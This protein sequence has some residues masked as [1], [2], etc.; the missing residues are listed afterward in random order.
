MDPSEKTFERLLGCLA[1]DRM[2]RS[3]SPECPGEVL[4]ATYMD[5]GLSASDLSWMV[6]HLADCPHCRQLVALQVGASGQSMVRSQAAQK[7]WIQSAPAGNSDTLGGFEAELA[8]VEASLGIKPKA[9]PADPRPHVLIVDDNVLYL[10]AL[11][12]TLAM[13][14]HVTACGSGREALRR[15]DENIRT[16]VLDIKM[17]DLNGLD[18]ADRLRAAGH[19]APIIFNT[20]YPGDFVREDIESRYRPF[21]YVTKDDPD[22]LLDCVRRAAGFPSRLPA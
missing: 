4:V 16:I 13:E 19:S 18:V 7:E 21:G 22:R 11:T 1:D 15:I 12:D 8:A 20:G 10:S 3:P 17:A 9:A 2:D 14:F 5:G 6:A